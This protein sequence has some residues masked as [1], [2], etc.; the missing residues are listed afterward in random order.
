ML[1]TKP[2]VKI[3]SA[4]KEIISS[5]SFMT[6]DTTGGEIAVQNLVIKFRFFTD[7]NGIRMD[8]KVD[9]VSLC[10][11]LYNFN[12]VMG[13]STTVPMEIG[14]LMG[15]RLFLGFHVNGLDSGLKLINYTLYLGE[16]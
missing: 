10:V 1:F 8:N 4:G 14:K 12:N 13:T 2:E 7:T 6:F 3:T 11:N 16:V 5:G 15:R 9:G